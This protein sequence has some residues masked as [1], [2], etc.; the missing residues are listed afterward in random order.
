MYSTK[1]ED[2]PRVREKWGPRNSGFT[3]DRPK[4]K[5]QDDNC[6]IGLENTQ[7]KVEADTIRPQKDRVQE[8]KRDKNLLNVS[9]RREIQRFKVAQ[10]RVKSTWIRKNED[11]ISYN[12]EK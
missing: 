8:N 10:E 11:R 5:L 6:A 2:T 9:C 3:L 4:G 1:V 12:Q 7:S